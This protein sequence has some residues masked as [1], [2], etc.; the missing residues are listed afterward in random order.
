MPNCKESWQ[1]V[2][3]L[4]MG[5][6][7]NTYP[8]AGYIFLIHVGI[9]KMGPLVEMQQ[10]D[11]ECIDEMFSECDLEKMKPILLSYLRHAI[12]QMISLVSVGITQFRARL[13]FWGF[14][15][16]KSSRM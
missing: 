15:Q 12:S 6:Y 11:Y 13:H 4:Q 1:N 8:L 14:Y 7:P 2:R 3:C 16:K 5:T 9:V 10:K